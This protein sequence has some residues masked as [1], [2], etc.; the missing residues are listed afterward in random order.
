[1][2]ESCCLQCSLDDP[3][4]FI[5][6]PTPGFPRSFGSPDMPVDYRITSSPNHRNRLGIRSASDGYS[7][8]PLHPLDLSGRVGSA[9]RSELSDDRQICQPRSRHSVGIPTRCPGVVCR[10]VL[11]LLRGT[12]IWT[13]R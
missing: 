6:C 4:P 11:Y 8:G 1:M 3:R 5:L 2:V 9:M 7:G 12:H 10:L 13:C